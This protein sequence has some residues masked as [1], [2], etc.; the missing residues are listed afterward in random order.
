[1]KAAVLS[2]QKGP[3]ELKEVPVP[4]PQAGQ[5]LIRVCAS[6]LCYTD[7]HQT[8]HK[9]PSYP[10]VLGHEPVGE[11]IKLGPNVKTRK[12]GERVGVPWVQKGCGKCEACLQD[13][14]QE[15]NNAI[16][17][18]VNIPGGH[19]QYLVAYEEGAVPLPDS[20]SYEQAAPLFCAGYTVWSAIRMAEPKAG[21]RIAV[22][23]I[24]GLGHLAIQLARAA[25]YET[26]AVTNTKDK[27]SLA[28]SLG[29][30]QV[31]ANGQELSDKGGADI[32]LSTTNSYK[33]TADAMRGLRSNGRV[34]IIGIDSNPLVLPW[35]LIARQIRVIA[36][37]Q[38]PRSYLHE[39]LQIAAEG[40]VKSLI[41]EFPLQEVAKAYERVSTGAVRFRAVIKA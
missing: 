28:L 37:Q 16:E 41:E 1:M 12:L 40:K 31:V 21:E 20:L 36:V 33:T 7:I 26:V 23:G 39:V 32:L 18:G 14:T 6:G 24:G 8:H 4:E 19:A 29:A 5:V 35:R 30:S 15:C 25:G 27:I 13:K 2:Q 11:I 34:M 3:W 9:L 38:G 10:W 22:L 17:T